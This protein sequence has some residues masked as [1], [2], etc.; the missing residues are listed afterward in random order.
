MGQSRGLFL[1]RITKMNHVADGTDHLDLL[2]L[3]LVLQKSLQLGGIVEM[4]LD[5]DFASPGDDN[6]DLD[7]GSL[8]LLDHVL[9]QGLI[10]DGK[11]LFGL[12]FGGWQKSGAQ[13][14]GWK[15]GLAH[16]S[17]LRCHHEIP[18]VSCMK[19][20]EGKRRLLDLAPSMKRRALTDSARAGR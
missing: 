4:V 2:G 18:E 17:A 19:E 20:L 6:N 9:N 11:H 12:R 13:P 10:N 15:D 5:S 16:A 7:S 1:P 14:S 8:A 3:P